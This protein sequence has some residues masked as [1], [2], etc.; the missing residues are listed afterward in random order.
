MTM[1][2][3]QPSTRDEADHSTVSLGG[4]DALIGYHLR[5]AQEASF[6]HFAALAHEELDPGRFAI[7]TIIGANEGI[8]Q[9][10]LSEAS[11][12]DKSTLTVTLRYL[13]AKGLIERVRTERDRRNYAIRLTDAGRQHLAE[14]TACAAQHEAD[15]DRI[16][17][18]ANKQALI[19]MLA[20]ITS[21]FR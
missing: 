14:L 19:R 2:K 8:N 10:A 16:V 12:R 5:Q 7:L 4:M 13:L 15:L 6:S 18:V 20:A 1:P 17:G 11:G 9:T 21:A 3:R